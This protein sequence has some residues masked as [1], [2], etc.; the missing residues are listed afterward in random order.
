[1][2][3]LHV[4]LAMMHRKYS[5]IYKIENEFD[6]LHSYIYQMQVFS[7]MLKRIYLLAK[8]LVKAT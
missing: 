1:M 4:M 2:G 3:C 8:L 6:H 5:P 7:D